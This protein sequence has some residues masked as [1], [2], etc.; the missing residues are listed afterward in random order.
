V[1]GDDYAAAV[2]VVAGE[3]PS[4]A[5]TIAAAAVRVAGI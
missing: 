1:G 5:A 3:A 4:T 2:G